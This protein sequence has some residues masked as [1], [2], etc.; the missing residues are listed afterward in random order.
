[1]STEDNAA[2]KAIDELEAVTRL[3]A[4]ELSAFRLRAQRAEAARAEMAGGEYDVV[5]VRSRIV[6]LE[7]EN[8]DL[9]RRTQEAGERVA[10]LLGRLRFLEEQLMTESVER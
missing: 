8:K 2:L 5:A 7:A 9:R 6:E 1:V 4:E 3:L 10:N